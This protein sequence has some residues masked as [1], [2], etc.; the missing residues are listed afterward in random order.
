V[1]GLEEAGV[2]RDAVALPDDGAGVLVD[3]VDAPAAGAVDAITNDAQ[4]RVRPLQ[5]LVARRKLDAPLDRAGVEIQ[6]MDTKVAEVRDIPLDE[7][8][9]ITGEVHPRHELPGAVRDVQRNG[10]GLAELAL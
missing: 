6:T 2:A 8:I 3:G 10:V 4:R 7:R 5:A 1:A 9:V